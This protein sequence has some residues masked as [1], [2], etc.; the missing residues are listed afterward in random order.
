MPSEWSTSPSFNHRAELHGEDMLSLVS[1]VLSQSH[2]PIAVA[3][4]TEGLVI[5]CRAEVV[6][7]VTVWSVLGGRLGNDRR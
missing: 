5:L 7:V 3:M 6:D 4:V 1:H 2:D